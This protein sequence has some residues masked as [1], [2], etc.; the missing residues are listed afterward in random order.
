MKVTV[1]RK[2]NVQDVPITTEFIKLQDAMKFAN[3]VE[4]GGE[5][6]VVIQEG[7]VSVNGEVCTQRGRKLRPGDSFTFDGITC[8]ITEA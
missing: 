5:A 8:R 6:K 3:L 4:S 1:K 7:D 2:A